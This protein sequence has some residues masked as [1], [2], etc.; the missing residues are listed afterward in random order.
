[1]T[2]YIGNAVS[3]E[4][5]RASGGEPG[6][7]TGKELRIQPWYLNKKGWRVFRPKSAEIAEKLVYDMRA[8]CD[9]MNIGYS[10]EK[11]NTLYTAAK[12]YNFDCALVETPCECDCSSL[13]RV[14]ICYA[15]IKISNFNTVSE[16]QRLLDT[17]EFIEMEGEEYTDSPNKLKAGDILV[18]KTKGHT[19]LVLNDGPDVDPDPPT[20]PDPPVPPEPPV[21]DKTV[22][23]VAKSVFV[24]KGDGI[25]SRIMFTAHRGNHFKLIDI[26][27]SGWYHIE[28]YK[29]EGYITNKEKYTKLVET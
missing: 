7:Q 17:G 13:V 23:A 14:C 25:L 4:K 22:V 6:N 15:G 11:R 21:E 10:Q 27:E 5:G 3:N 19:A 26:A 1:M 18:T 12:P 2:V 8:A 20:P 9:N 24:R 28:T 29:G 16:P